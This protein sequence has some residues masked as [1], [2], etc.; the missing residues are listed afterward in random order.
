MAE[1]NT[2][3]KKSVIQRINEGE[4]NHVQAFL[5]AIDERIKH[6]EELI[7]KSKEQLKREGLQDKKKKQLL[8]VTVASGLKSAQNKNRTCTTKNG[9]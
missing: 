8:I 7:E 1:K 6:L 3:E 9:H 2:M 4:Q 5:A